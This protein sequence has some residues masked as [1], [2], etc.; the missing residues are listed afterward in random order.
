M[1][2]FINQFDKKCELCGEYFQPEDIKVIEGANICKECEVLEDTIEE[3]GD[4]ETAVKDYIKKGYIIL[5]K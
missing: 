2:Q 5:N 4:I 1:F 3:F